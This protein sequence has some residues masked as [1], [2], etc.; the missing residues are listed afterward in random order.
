MQ[1]Y[2]G[3][4]LECLDLSFYNFDPYGATALAEALKT[5]LNLSEL[6]L[7]NNE[8]KDIGHISLSNSLRLLKKI[9][10]LDFSKTHLGFIGLKNYT[11]TVKSLYS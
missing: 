4:G 8:I 7:S 3:P 9:S 5:S 6:R 1:R 11:N 10:Y 2:G